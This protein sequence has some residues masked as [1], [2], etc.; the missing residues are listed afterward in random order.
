MGVNCRSIWTCISHSTRAEETTVVKR[1]QTVVI[2]NLMNP[3]LD[4]E[5]PLRWRHNDHDGVSNHQPGG[6]LLNRLFRRRSKET[7]KLRVPVLCVGNSPGPVNFPHKGPVTREMFPFHDAIVSM[8]WHKTTVNPVLQQ[9]SYYSLT[10]SHQYAHKFRTQC[11][12]HL[13]YQPHFLQQ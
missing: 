8:A 7:S 9:W 1:L 2:L 12:I 10:Q 13:S 5:Y 11:V 3:C 6:C 4:R